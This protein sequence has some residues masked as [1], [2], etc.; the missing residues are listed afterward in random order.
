MNDPPLI[1]V[2]TTE[3]YPDPHNPPRIHPC[4]PVRPTTHHDYTHQ[5]PPGRIR[6][7]TTHHGYTVVEQRLAEDDDV[8]N[9]V[10]LNR[11][12]DGEHGDWIDG[13]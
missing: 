7:P 5:D 8:E 1:A 13:G 12:E 3:T 9:L 11:F 6:T 2:T 4:R 10:D